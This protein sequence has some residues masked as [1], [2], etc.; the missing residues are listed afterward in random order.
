MTRKIDEASTYIAESRAEAELLAAISQA[1]VTGEVTIPRSEKESARL[2]HELQTRLKETGGIVEAAASE[3]AGTDRLR[4]DLIKLLYSWL[5]R[6]LP[7][8]AAASSQD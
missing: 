7:T 8:A 2:K 6:G 4:Y 1:G 5:V 3:A